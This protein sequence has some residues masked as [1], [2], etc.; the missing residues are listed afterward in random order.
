MFCCRVYCA[1]NPNHLYADMGRGRSCWRG[2]AAA[3]AEE[4]GQGHAAGGC[5]SHCADGQQSAVLQGMLPRRLLVCI[6]LA[7]PASVHLGCILCSHCVLHPKPPMRAD[8]H[9]ALHPAALPD[10]CRNTQLCSLNAP[11]ECSECSKLTAGPL[12]AGAEREH[13][14]RGV[15]SCWVT[16]RTSFRTSSCPWSMSA[17]RWGCLILTSW[18]MGTY[19]AHV[20][21][22]A[23]PHIQQQ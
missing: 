18:L 22:K 12:I 15:H 11:F 16:W 23:A 1:D 21:S 7:C 5:Q 6:M 20:V 3:R 19:H 8:W 17:M 2:R 14:Q 13:G 9:P 4:A 10:Y